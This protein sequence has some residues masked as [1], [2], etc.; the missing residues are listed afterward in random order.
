MNDYKGDIKIV[1]KHYVVHPGSATIPALAS[2]AANRQGKFKKMYQ[3]IWDKGFDAGRNL[4]QENM[5]KLAK[6]AG[7]DMTKYKADMEGYCKTFIRK[8]QTDLAK[9]GAR[10]TPAF[11]INGRFLSGARPVDQFKAIVDE[12][13]KKANDR[14]AKGT[15]VQDYYEEWV[16][17]KGKKSL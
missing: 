3:L 5:D 2:C 1:Y 16:V 13:L 9:V 17:K 4:G 7:L 8:D 6:E 14:I 10:G 11:F 15:K 12:E